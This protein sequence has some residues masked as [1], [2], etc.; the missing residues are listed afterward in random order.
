MTWADFKTR[1]EL[2]LWRW[3]IRCP[4]CKNSSNSLI[5]WGDGEFRCSNCGYESFKKGD[6]RK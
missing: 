2:R 1:V 4:R 5:I 6:W 3:L